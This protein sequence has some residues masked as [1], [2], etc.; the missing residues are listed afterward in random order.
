MLLQ[1]LND[2]AAALQKIASVLRRIQPDAVHINLPSR[3]P[4]E[5]WVRPSDEEGLMRAT[6]ML[7]DIAGVVSPAKGRFDLAGHDN[8]IDAIIAI[9][10][11]HPMHQ[12]ELECALAQWSLDQVDEGLV[13]LEASGQAQ[14]V[15]RLGRRFWSAAPAHYP[16]EA[17]S[18]TSAP[19]E[20]HHYR[21]ENHKDEAGGE[22]SCSNIGTELTSQSRRIALNK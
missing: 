20:R 3:P 11:R 6:A 4:A 21:G 12:E 13:A 18:L 19:G 9:I 16:G 7:G 14:V 5:T 22:K 15:E 2:D 8:V 10:T 1:G 17:R